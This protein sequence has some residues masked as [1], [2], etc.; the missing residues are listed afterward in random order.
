MQS[1]E[2]NF[3]LLQYIITI[4][5][6]YKQ[7]VITYNRTI[8]IEKT[9]KNLEKIVKNVIQNTADSIDTKMLEQNLLKTMHVDN[10]KVLLYMKK[11]E[12]ELIEQLDI[13]LIL[14]EVV[15][16]DTSLKKNMQ[17]STTCH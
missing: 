11:I 16:T 7:S 9:L 1:S 3:K 6:S 8:E 2:R 15:L 4:N 17:T 10:K 5:N 12:N 13:T 14:I